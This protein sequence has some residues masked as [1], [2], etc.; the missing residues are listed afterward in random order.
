[1]PRV[2]QAS[3]NGA[4]DHKNLV[5]RTLARPT[6]TLM[7]T[8]ALPSLLFSLHR[9]PFSNNHRGGGGGVL[10]RR[11][12]CVTGLSQTGYRTAA[13][14]GSRE[15]LHGQESDPASDVVLGKA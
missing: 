1:M 7:P 13:H 11:V 5:Q 15:S 4:R 10:T 2:I 8:L 6:P 14:N 3:C 9:S 12:S